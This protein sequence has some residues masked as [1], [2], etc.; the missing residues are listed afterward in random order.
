MFARIRSVWHLPGIGQIGADQLS[1]V[2]SAAPAAILCGLLNTAILAFD[3]WPVVPRIE[4][5]AWLMCAL[6]ASIALSLRGGRRQPRDPTALSKR[7]LRRVVLGAVLS[8]CPWG[9]LG[10]LN[11]GA[12]PHTKELILIAVCAGMVA[13]GSI[14][15]A[16]LYP[17][18]LAYIGVI[19]VP[20]ALTCFAN[21]GPGYE[22]LGLLT[23]SYGAFLCAVIATSARL[24]VERA[25]A[26]RALKL[27]DDIISSQNMRFET[28]LNNMSQGLC[29]FDGDERLIVCNRRYIE[30][31]G[32]AAD[33][34]RPGTSLRDIVNMRYKAGSC[35]DM[36][37]NQYLAWRS[38]VGRFNR[39]SDTV[40]RLKNGRVFAI[41]Y[42]P[43]PD[44]AWVS[45]TDDI[46]E[47][48]QLSEEL[49]ERT[50]LLQAIIDNFPGGIGFYDRDLRVVVCNEKAKEILDLPRQLFA[51][52]PPRLVD[53][54]SF[55]AE[56]GE[57]GPGDV[58]EQ[59]AAKLALATDRVPYR[60]ERTRPDGTVLDVR[61]APIVNGGFI[62]TYMDI[63][64]RYRAEAKIAHMATH[65]ALTGLPNRVLFRD[66]LDKA[67]D[68]SR[69]GDTAVA[70]MMLDLNRF[71][72]VN[73]TLG[74]P[75]GDVLLKAV[76]DRLSIAVRSDDIVARL[77]G[78]EFAVLVH[79][80]DPTSDA[81]SIAKRIHEVL[82]APFDLGEHRV[83][84]GT[85]IG[86][87]ITSADASHPDELI[88]RADVALYRAKQGGGDRFRFFELAMEQRRPAE[89]AQ[90]QPRASAA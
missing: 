23:L 43:M 62:T 9:L 44:G 39:P 52:G 73:D 37:P 87:A 80:F 7:T 26:L 24:S 57:Y 49:A 74:H 82:S 70:V 68:A 29:F 14:L 50:A 2:L 84:I 90:P 69:E 33:R 35:P 27:R 38:S 31:Y 16:P 18:A 36:S 5:V 19:L 58:A 53:I 85:S 21:A 17:A 15:L 12:L 6:C 48:Q 89:D 34:V 76:A 40:H 46:T 3:L 41:H 8:A 83:E 56:R 54:L 25:E 1:A 59:V 79:T 66:R 61:G 65:D 4:L 64:E 86:I 81:T 10:A 88:K 47:A 42:R 60:F 55:N 11:L 77:G 72:Q 32:L 63:T 75:A 45:T 30:M 67:L 13:G 78:D 71:K 20:F 22:L 28:A 51:H